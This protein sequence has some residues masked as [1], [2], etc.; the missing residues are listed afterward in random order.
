MDG[1][2]RRDYNKDL[3]RHLEETLAKCD[4]LEK[5]LDDYKRKSEQEFDDFK[6]KS[7]QELDDCHAKIAE[8]EA[9]IVLKDEQIAV[10]KAD[11]ER[12]KRIINSNSSNSS[13]PPSS[14]QKPSK[15]ANTYNSRSKTGRKPGGQPGHKG[16][17]LTQD[18]VETLL[19]SGECDHVV[20]TFGG[21][22]GEFVTRY[23]LDM[24]V[25]LVV[26]EL[27]F[28]ADADGAST[29]PPEL[30]SVVT[31][32]NTVKASGLA[33]AYAGNVP[34][35]R[36]CDILSILS[37]GYIRLSPGSL[38]KFSESLAEGLYERH[39]AGI[40][41]KLMNSE[42]LC[43]DSTAVTVN[44]VQ[45]YI[46]NQ[47]TRDAVLYTPTVTKTLNEMERVG[48]LKDYAGVCVHDHETAVYHFGTGHAECN[49]HILRYLRKNSEE[50]GNSWSA[51][52]AELLL[53]MNSEVQAHESRT[54]PELELRT[55]SEEYDN[56]L[57]EGRTQNRRISGVAREEEIKLIRRMERCRDNHLLF[58][59][60]PEVPFTNNMSERDLRKCK[61][62]QKISG[63]FRKDAGKQ[64]YCIVMSIIESCKRR[65]ENFLGVFLDSLAA[66]PL[67]V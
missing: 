20:E 12:L 42:V 19:G 65:N 25:R 29:L 35:K 58:A 48:I 31:Y 18:Q 33:L 22:D 60:H 11:N 17:T 56:I 2:M 8:L 53:E 28:Y 62:R 7:E 47:S 41:E 39:I 37:G 38:Y 3:F 46:R 54:I 4:A 21:P 24:R 6:R 55:F 63:G 9:V 27:R 50:T 26:R 32:G 52:M 5:K 59:S 67:P 23:V 64:I 16:C 10:L 45:Q 1:P 49:A 44:G 66:A 57:R 34:L 43:T 61:N 36:T 15:P 51:R 40:E 30:N 14:D 13:L